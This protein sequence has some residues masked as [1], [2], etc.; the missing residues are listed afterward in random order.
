MVLGNSATEN[1]DNKCNNQAGGDGA[2][3]GKK[4]S[5]FNKTITVFED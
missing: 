4:S 2:N 3:G 5:K 1:K